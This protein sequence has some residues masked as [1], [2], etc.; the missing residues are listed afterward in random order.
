MLHQTYLVVRD[1][2]I[3]WL[4]EQHAT[5]ALVFNQLNLLIE[6]RGRH[7]RFA[8]RALPPS[9]LSA[10]L[11]VRG[12]FSGRSF[13]DLK[14]WRGQLYTQ[15]DYADV[16]A[17]RTW[18][19]LPVGFKRGRGA[20]RGWLGVAEGKVNQV[21]ADLALADVGAQLA[22]GLSPLDLHTLRGRVGWMDSAQG[23]EVST[24]R[25]SLRTNDVTVPPTDFYLRLVHASGKQPSGGEI[26]ASTLE[27]A[28]LVTLTDSLPLS[29]D[30]KQHLAEFAPQGTVSGL[31]AKWQ[32]DADKPAH[33]EV[34]AKFDQLS[35]KRTDKLPGFSGLS[36]ELDGSDTTGTLSLSAHNLTVDAPQIM[37]EPL[38]FDSLTAQGSWQSKPQGMEVKFSNVTAANAD[39]AGTVFG[40]FQA[41]PD[42]HGLIDLN[43]NLAHAA[44]NHADRY[45][46]LDAIDKDTHA[47]L[48]KALLDGQAEDFHLRLQGDL[49]DFPFP[50]N[51]K[52]LF[53]IQAHIK[54]GALEYAKD[55]PR[56]DN[57]AGELLIQGKRLE[58]NAPSAMTV[59]VRLQKVRVVH[60]GYGKSRHDVASAWRSRRRNRTQP[61]LYPEKSGAW[62]SRRS[63]RRYE[64]SR[65]RQ[66]ATGGEYPVARQQ[67]R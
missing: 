61:G 16:A 51:K 60:A 49:N 40:S 26:R 28:H 59:G 5:P 19:P 31:Q 38:A 4:D 64:S 42:S 41:L 57:I 33:Y 45:I 15:L 48:R 43:I 24:T 46:P 1:A 3:T 17:W 6:N 13:N 62:L 66:P 53:Q 21:T 34:K 27:L 65:Q 29:K 23:V 7:H 2:R 25:L 52:G 9:E 58:V 50:E 44:I 14:A 67:S 36:G 54:D 32:G 8:L 63:H 56:I 30:W 12:D 20:L 47:W 35:M 22:E 55:W 10:Q 37:P 11:D 39:L 18:L